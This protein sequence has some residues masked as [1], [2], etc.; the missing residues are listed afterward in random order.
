M[1]VIA[2]AL[3]RCLMWSR[4][5]VLLDEK[6]TITMI[7]GA[8]WT[9]LH[10]AMTIMTEIHVFANN[11][12]VVVPKP[13]VETFRNSFMYQ[14]S[15]LWNSLPPHFKYASTHD[16]FKKRLYKKEYFYAPT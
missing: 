1:G 15:I 11:M 7:T 9:G 13:N 14:G 8:H 12:N 10:E 16:S 3:K 6:P 4:I 5:F 2:I